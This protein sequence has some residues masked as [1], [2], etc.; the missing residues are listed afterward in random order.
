M[1]PGV[2][3]AGLHALID[4]L[5]RFAESRFPVR[6]VHAFLQTAR[7]PLSELQPY[8]FIAPD[9]Y[10]RNLIYKCPE[11][12]LLLVVWP[13]GQ[14]SPVHGHEGEKC[15]AR[16]EQ[17][18]LRFTNF[19]EIREGDGFRLQKTSEKI[20]DAGHLDGPADIHGVDNL[21]DTLALSLHVYSH[22]YDA[23]DIYDVEANIKT[24]KRMHYDSRFGIPE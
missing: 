23:C 1:T 17:G 20:G 13:P 4:R 19:R 2:E 22:P 5:N 16:V 12:E 6:E 21:F 15:W 7:I 10:T 9:H 3:C 11:F 24:R 18:R 8:I 14:G